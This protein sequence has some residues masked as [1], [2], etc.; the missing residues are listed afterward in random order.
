MVK[1]PDRT[2]RCRVVAVLGRAGPK[3]ALKRASERPRRLYTAVAVG[4]YRPSGRQPS[5]A[6]VCVRGVAGWPP[7]ASYDLQDD[8][9]DDA[10]P[11]GAPRAT[12]ARVDPAA[13]ERQQKTPGTG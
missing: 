11:P 10:R 9:Q 2:A 8:D 5:S 1:T 4:L 3:T 6:C 7:G 13:L 12:A